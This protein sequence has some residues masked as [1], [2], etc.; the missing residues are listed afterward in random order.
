MD[1]LR[2][3][4]GCA[5]GF[6]L[7]RGGRRPDI[8][9]SKCGR[10]QS[11]HV[12]QDSQTAGVVDCCDTGRNEVGV[13]GVVDDVLQLIQ[14]TRLEDLHQICRG[15][16]ARLRQACK[17]GL[18]HQLVWLVRSEAE[19][20]LGRGGE[21]ITGERGRGV[22]EGIHLDDIVGPAVDRVDDV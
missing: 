5:C 11:I 3:R 18:D 12:R 14:H 21:G 6:T 8:Y 9:G 1:Q 19:C 7:S 17:A 13:C 2:P 4:N 22:E 20:G 15:V 16:K 10:P